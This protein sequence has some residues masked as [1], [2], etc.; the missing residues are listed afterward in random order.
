[1]T[2]EE[3]QLLKDKR[4][5]LQVQCL[6]KEAALQQL[7]IEN[8]QADLDYNI[9]LMEPHHFCHTRVYRSP[10]G[11]SWLCVPF[12]VDRGDMASNYPYGEGRTPAEAC[13]NFDACWREGDYSEDQFRDGGGSSI[14]R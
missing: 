11:D 4:L 10:D 1:M 5:L 9:S 6:H 2:P 12:N 8:A 13:R 7:R 14:V 3:R